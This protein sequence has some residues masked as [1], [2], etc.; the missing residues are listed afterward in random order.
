LPLGRII[1]LHPYDT[2]F[3]RGE[4]KSVFNFGGSAVVV[5]GE[6]RVWCPADDILSNTKQGIETCVLL[7]DTI[8]VRTVPK[9]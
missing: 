5:F 8:T 9:Q 6:P 4:E 3:Q 1:Q 2:P 7:G